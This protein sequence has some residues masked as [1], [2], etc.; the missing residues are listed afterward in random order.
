MLVAKYGIRNTEDDNMVEW[1][2]QKIEKEMEVLEKKLGGIG[3]KVTFSH[4][5]LNLVFLVFSLF[6]IILMF[7]L[8]GA[9][10]IAIG[11]FAI[12]ALAI[13]VMKFFTNEARVNHYQLW[14]LKSIE[15]RL[16]NM[17]KELKSIEGKISK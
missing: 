11:S 2:E 5:I 16:I 9:I 17:A 3:G 14:V 15:I 12:S 6:L 4:A 13:W 10:Q 8:E 7:F 1:D